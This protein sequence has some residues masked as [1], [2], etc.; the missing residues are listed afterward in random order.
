[1]CVIVTLCDNE[2][3][4]VVPTVCG[5]SKL[6][7][8]EKPLGI[9]I[10]VSKDVA[11][12]SPNSVLEGS[13]KA[14]ASTAPCVV[15]LISKRILLAR[16]IKSVSVIPISSV[17]S[18]PAKPEDS[19][20]LAGP[21]TGFDLPIVAYAM[22]PPTAPPNRIRPSPGNSST[23]LEGPS[24][25]GVP[26]PPSVS[27]VTITSVSGKLGSLRLRI[28]PAFAVIEVLKSSAASACQWPK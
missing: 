11:K 27:S 17:P 4:P 3:G 9:S 20:S 15:P 18:P 16:G 14:W 23:L 5:N 1:M 19:S 28:S 22:K 6:V 7:D 10:A 2:Y 26:I 21:V 12:A 25:V 24:I 8:A 13:I